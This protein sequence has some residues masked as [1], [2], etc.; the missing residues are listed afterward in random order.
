MSDEPAGTLADTDQHAPGPSSVF[1]AAL[2]GGILLYQRCEACGRNVFYP[3]LACPYCG[4]PRLEWRES[5]GR[6]TVYSTTAVSRRGGDPYN[7]ALIDLDEGIRMMSK[8]VGIPAEAVAIG[9]TVRM[10][11][12]RV[13]GHPVAVFRPAE[14]PG[15]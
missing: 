1:A 4:C 13:D 15:S 10:E 12:E 11:V 9:T 8:V 2:A 14:E 5:A 7:V 6:G 3:R